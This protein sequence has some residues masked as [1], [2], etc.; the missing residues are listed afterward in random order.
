MIKGSLLTKYYLLTPVFVLIEFLVNANLR[1]TI[2]MGG[3]YFLYMGV[4][5]AI[6]GFFIKSPIVLNFF[7]LVESTVNLILLF[8]SVYLPIFFLSK[9]PEST[10]TH[11]FEMTDVIHF[12]MVGVVLLYAFYTNP[13]IKKKRF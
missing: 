13:L 8:K 11:N 5:F 4:C 7:A 3:Y 10:D 9:L 12:I 6:G 1:I 2:P